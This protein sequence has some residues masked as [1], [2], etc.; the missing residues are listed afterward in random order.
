MQKNAFGKWLLEQ[1]RLIVLPP[2]YAAYTKTL[3]YVCDG[4]NVAVHVFFLNHPEKHVALFTSGVRDNGLSFF[5]VDHV[6]FFDRKSGWK[7]K[8]SMKDPA[9]SVDEIFR[10][11]FALNTMGGKWQFDLIAQHA[12]I[13]GV[14][15]A[16]LNSFGGTFNM[17]VNKCCIQS[18]PKPSA[19]TMS[20]PFA[21]CLTSADEF[22]GNLSTSFSNHSNSMES[23]MSA[24][25]LV[26]AT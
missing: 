11:V 9:K 15:W 12:H 24:S 22:Y 6:L 20:S 4:G 18:Q 23:Q 16:N 21:M 26:M 10:E 3:R 7:V 13:L 19:L 2:Q 17:F 14:K 5:G 8:R 1:E 25:N